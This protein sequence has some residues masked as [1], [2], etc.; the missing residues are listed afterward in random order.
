MTE[1]NQIARRE[2][3]V[4]HQIRGRGIGSPAVIDAM[5]RVPREAFVPDNQR[6]VAYHDTPLPI[7]ANQTISQPYINTGTVAAA[8]DWDAPM[9]IKTLRPVLPESYEWLC[10]ETGLAGFLLPLG[11]GADPEV[12]RSLSTPRLQRAIGVIYRPDTERASHYFETELPRQFD[13]YIWIDHSHAVTT[14]DSRELK[15]MPDT[16]PFGL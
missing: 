4:D 14:L 9:E 6:N 12:R 7:A 10:H 2:A 5:R 13:E 11:Q 15:G 3:M 8:A 1:H 16:Y